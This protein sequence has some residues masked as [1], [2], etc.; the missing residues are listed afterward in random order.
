[1]DE[2]KSEAQPNTADALQEPNDPNAEAPIPAGSAKAF[3]QSGP[4]WLYDEDEGI[5]N[6]RD[7]L[8][9]DYNQ[10]VQL[11]GGTRQDA[12]DI[13][14]KD[15]PNGPLKAGEDTALRAF[16]GAS[17]PWLFL[18]RAFAYRTGI[19]NT[20]TFVIIAGILGGMLWYGTQSKKEAPPPPPVLDS[21]AK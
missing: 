3:L 21:T 10:W 4:T 15:Y 8:L 9:G 13:F 2:S 16:L 20:V 17:F 18:Y 6:A 14:L 12:L 19:F 5:A 7:Q 1:M 11:A